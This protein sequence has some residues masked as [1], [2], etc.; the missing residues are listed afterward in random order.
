MNLILVKMFA[1]ALALGQVTT[2]PE[3]VKTEFDPDI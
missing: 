1:M 3:A 2:R